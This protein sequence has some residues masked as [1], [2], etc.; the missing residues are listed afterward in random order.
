MPL[1][2]R[3]TSSTVAGVLALALAGLGGSAAADTTQRVVVDPDHPGGW[4]SH[5]YDAS[6]GEELVPVQRFG[7]GPDEAPTGQGSLVVELGSG[8]ANRVETFSTARFDGLR[9]ADLSFGRFWAYQ[10]D[11]KL[12]DGRFESPKPATLSFAVDTDADGLY[13]PDGDDDLLLYLPTDN[14]PAAHASWQSGSM[15]G[16]NWR[17]AGE[18]GVTSFERYVDAHPDAVLADDLDATARGSVSFVISGVTDGTVALD[19]IAMA[20]SRADGSEDWTLF[21]FEPTRPRVSISNTSVREGNRDLLFAVRLDQTYR[22]SVGIRYRT[23]GGTATPGVDYVAREGSVTIPAGKR[24]AT[25]AVRVLGDEQY[26]GPETVGVNL[27]APEFGVVTDQRGR[28]RIV[29]DDTSVA[30]TARNGRSTRIRIDLGTTPQRA[31]APV[32]VFAMVDGSQAER[33]FRGRTGDSGELHRVLRREFRHGDEVR[34]WA[35]LTTVRGSYRSAN[36]SI[37]ID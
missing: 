7:K 1:S 9:L 27:G 14:G 3:R 22:D 32:K 34:V 26:E 17:V 10:R 29:D 18:W 4:V 20:F 12:E 24:T 21:D 15:A 8:D 35:V 36:R 33:V 30:L 13:E 31:H 11:D 25:V 6:T 37:T 19:D 5:A 23:R 28:G 2:V 16:G